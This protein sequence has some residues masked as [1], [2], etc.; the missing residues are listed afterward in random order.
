VLAGQVGRALRMLDGLCAEGEAAVLVHWTLAEDLRALRRIQ[1]ALRDGK[2][3]PLALRE[4]RV[5]GAKERLLERVLPQLAEAPLDALVADAHTVDGIVK[6]L[7]DPAWP[8]DPW[9]ALRRLMLQMMEALRAPERG[10]LATR[11]LALR[12]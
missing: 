10:L 12:P 5:W 2:P 3:P 6:G 9:E 1:L 7:R 8:L 4:A 11:H